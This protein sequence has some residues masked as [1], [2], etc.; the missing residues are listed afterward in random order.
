MELEEKMISLETKIAYLENFVADLNQV[1]ID[2]EKCIRQLMLETEIIKK[3][4]D[5]KKEKLPEMEK[6]PHY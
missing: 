4:I 1:I 2:Q 5:E 3:E 6:P